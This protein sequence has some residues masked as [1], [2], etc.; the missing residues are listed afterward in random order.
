M[1][2]RDNS[3]RRTSWLLGALTVVVLALGLPATSGATMPGA[4]GRIAFE[5]VVE[6]PEFTSS[7]QVWSMNP[8]GSG[9]TQ[10]TSGKDSNE[11]VYSPDGSRLAF[12]RY[13]EVWVAA[14]DGSG[15][16]ALT[17]GTEVETEPTR[18]VHQTYE[19][20][21][22]TKIVEH[23]DQRDDFSDPAFAPDGKTLA[24]AHF[25]GTSIDKYSCGVDNNGDTGCLTSTTSE[26]PCEGCG[27]SIQA[28]DSS[29]GALVAT[30]APQTDSVYLISPTYS[31]TGALAYMRE[32][33]YAKGEIQVLPTPGA[34][35]ITVATGEV[36]HPDFSPN[37]TR[38]AFAY[39]RHEIGIASVGGGTPTYIAAPAPSSKDVVWSVQS[40][41]WSPDGTAIAFADLGA[42][43]SEMRYT[44]G[45][46]YLVRP[47]G[48]GMTQIQG[49]AT[50]PTGWQPLAVPAPPP[51]PKSGPP[52]IHARRLTGK[53][54]LRLN[55]QGIAVVGKIAC[56]STA[57]SLRTL[58]SK[59]KVGKKRYG[60]PTIVA[61]SL[62]PGALAPLEIKVK[63]K[64]LAA[65]RAAHKGNLSLTVAVGD[66]S[67]T[68]N[69]PF[70]AKVLPA[71]PKHHRKKP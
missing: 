67:G 22:W 21:A 7:E 26:Y 71:A 17:V 23:R 11:A 3:A 60:V 56:G 43:E 15:A 42:K 46:V 19:G 48:T 6:G 35:P 52:A 51:V 62:A 41:V 50:V 1:R 59:L 47:D 31:P 34:A 57:C 61:K 63:G 5:K 49:E 58:S 45:G 30:L 69:L 24:V 38:V 32:T 12:S 27:S 16:R 37:G 29:T 39:G 70:A 28:I 65:L 36:E 25:R 4:D 53:G 8:D 68:Q 40:P 64:A 33:E 18:W 10:L 9:A 13:N 55:R 44:D 66:A 20:H 2:A 14:T 54:K